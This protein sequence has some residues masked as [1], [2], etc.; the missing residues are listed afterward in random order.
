M[1]PILALYIWPA[2]SAVLLGR[3]RLPLAILVV[4]FAGYMFLPVRTAI[5]FPMIPP[6]DKHVVPVLTVAVLLLLISKLQKGA[7]YLPG[8]LPKS[9]LAKVLM[10]LV[11]GGSFGTALTNG[12]Q[13]IT[14][15]ERLAA[16]RP[17]D[18]FSM[19]IIA[20]LLLLPVF[21]GRKYFAHPDTHR[22]ILIVMCITA[23]IYAVLAFY[24]V[25]MSPQLNRMFYGFTPHAWIQHVRG[26][27][28]RPM[29]F[30]EHGLRVSLFFALALIAS[31]GLFRSG[32]RMGGMA[33]AIVWLLIVL[34]LSKSLGALLIAVFAIPIVL[35]LNLR[36]MILI[37]A[38][39]GF[40]VLSYPILRGGGLV[41]VE[42]AISVFS[43][44]DQNRAASFQFRLDNE[45]L[46]LDRALERPLF[47]WGGFARN[48]VRDE[49]GNNI[50]VPDGYW[51]IIIGRSGWTGYIGEFGLM[52]MPLLFLFLYRGRL[53]INRDTA[54][55]SI[56]LAANMI[57]LIPN[58][59]QT[60]ITWLIVGALWGRLEMGKQMGSPDDDA[61][62]DDSDDRTA[63]PS[64][65]RDFGHSHSAR[66]RTISTGSSTAR[67]ARN[68]AIP[69][70]PGAGG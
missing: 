51:V 59:G 6:L 68:P 41:P 10:L 57:D 35:F 63:R 49:K 42:A 18:G 9:F 60:P 25:R 11:V 13:I 19:G 17:Y 29:V 64:Y 5:D 66:D 26:D 37:S 44:I 67:F 54:T 1:S 40:A 24:E 12:D 58:S 3:M 38:V 70:T 28:F 8:F 39:I 30:M 16:L 33:V 32:W 4:M 22:L 55:L 61:Q 2:L 36:M 52:V 69:D 23:C 15:L 20:V 43:K 7:I 48:F 45:D 21:I 50:S 65:A 47:G 27:G 14:P 46:L 53:D 62:I 34:V 31:V 56:I